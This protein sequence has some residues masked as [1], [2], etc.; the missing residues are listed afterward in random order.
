MK[1][2]LVI[3]ALSLVTTSFAQWENFK[4]EIKDVS[5]KDDIYLDAEYLAL[6]KRL[7]DGVPLYKKEILAEFKKDSIDD[8]FLGAL[9]AFTSTSLVEESFKKKI[10]KIIVTTKKPKDYRVTYITL[11]KSNKDLKLK[12]SR[13]EELLM[14][15]MFFLK[16]YATRKLEELEKK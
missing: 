9:L 6:E 3:I 4:K 14:T 5:L 1:N 12:R 11:I 16:S 13:L 10:F 2:T 7:N 15:D 8:F